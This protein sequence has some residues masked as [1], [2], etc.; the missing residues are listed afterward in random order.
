MK[1]VSLIFFLMMGSQIL[2]AHPGVEHHS[3]DSFVGEWAWLILPLVAMIAIALKFSQSR[4]RNSR[5]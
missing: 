2:L 3:H 5:K 1:K 4:S